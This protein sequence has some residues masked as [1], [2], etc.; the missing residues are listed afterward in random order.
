M[1]EKIISTANL[2]FIESSLNVLN[3][4]LKTVNDHVL[5][6]DNTVDE[7]KVIQDEIAVDLRTLKESF[8]E[9]VQEYRR[10]T[11]LQ[12][13]NT[14]IIEVRQELETKYGYYNEVRR[15]ATGILQ[16]VDKR[17]V[18][19]NALQTAT[20]EVMIKASGY[21]LAPTLVCVA[22][23]IRSD[24]ST[25]ERALR[26]S[27]ERDDYRTTIFF[28]LLTR[29]TNRVQPTVQWT[30]RYFLHQNPHDL[31]R[32]FIIVLES[33]ASG[34]FP[35][36]AKAI[37]IRNVKNWIKELTSTDD[38]INQQKDNWIRF[39]NAL[40][41]SNDQDY[42]AIKR[43]A[44]SWSLVEENLQ[45]AKANEKIL[46][47]FLLVLESGTIDKTHY[48]KKLDELL[49]LLVNNFDDEELPLRERERLC[50]LIIEKAGDVDAAKLMMDAEKKI[51]DQK[52]DFLQ[53]LTNAAFNPEAAGATTASQSLAI[54]I[55]APWII[56]AYNT[57]TAEYLN[58]HPAEIHFDI[59]GWTD[60]I[61][62]GSEEQK[63]LSK[64]AIF[65]DNL[66]QELW[67]KE[68]FP[69]AWWLLPV[70]LLLLGVYAWFSPD[71]VLGGALILISLIATTIVIIKYARNRKYRSS[72]SDQVE[73]TKLRAAAVL[74]RLIIEVVEYRDEFQKEHA[75]SGKVLE[76]LNNLDADLISTQTHGQVRTII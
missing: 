30:E 13:A 52:V 59:D 54:S 35:P 69:Q 67:D 58:V 61:T 31:D 22:S 75:K 16:A 6:I 36:A 9:Y 39:F 3:S 63:L 21:W 15:M 12:L 33:I 26:A 34:I 38:Y 49:N 76:F 32:E 64:Q 44:T 14:Q 53:L 11:E 5:V 24:K 71:K 57:F 74:R 41:D 50:T 73:D 56:E 28:M 48:I 65:Y 25:A 47:H 8:E 37:M 19:H 68:K 29:R 43:F 18:T 70:G 10:M 7:L 60:K 17:L 45:I 27:M 62:D 51:Y 46:Q 2:A 20:E 40:R 66:K 1:A 55:S 42:P 72:I 23:W 4:N